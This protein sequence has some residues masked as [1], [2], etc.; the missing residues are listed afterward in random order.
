MAEHS[1]PHR[2]RKRHPERIILR[3]LHHRCRCIG[4]D[5]VVAQMVVDVKVI[6]SIFIIAAID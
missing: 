5:P 2:I 6:I 1:P 4:Y 3:A